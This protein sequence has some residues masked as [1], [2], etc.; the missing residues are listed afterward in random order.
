MSHKVSF[1]GL[2]ERLL[3]G[4][5]EV[6]PQLG[7]QISECEGVE[8]CA[9]KGDS[10]SIRKAE[11]AV[12]ITYLREHQFFRML[13]FLPGVLKG[14]SGREEKPSFGMLCYMADMSRNAV[15]NLPTAKR[16]LRYLALMGYDSLMLYTED[17]FELPGY[18]YFGHMRGRFSQEELKEIDDYAYDLGIEVIP[19]VQTLAHLA[20]ALR[21]PGF[22]FQDTGDI[23]LVGDERTY[24]F[25][26]AILGVCAKCFRSRRINVGM[27][28]A[29]MLARGAYLDKNGYRP[30]SEVMLEHLDR[31]VK[32]CAENGFTPMIWSDM[33]FRM[34]FGGRYRVSEGEIAQEII[35]KVPESL[36]LIYWDYYSLDRGLFSH[37]LDCHKKF[38]NPVVFA[39]GAWKWYGFAPHNRFSIESTRMQLDVCR[40]KGVDNIIV[41]SWGDNGGEA[42]Q[43]SVL[44]A[45]IYFAE[46]G[47]AGGDV[48][49]ERLEERCLECFGIGY[50][51]LLTLD[52][53]NELPGV[54]VE[55]GRPVNPSRYLLFN[56][57]LEGLLDVHMDPE[58]TPAGFA[59]AA[60]RLFKYK[61]DPNF[62]YIFNTLGKLS[63][64]LAVKCDISVR[65]R[66]AYKR[67][68][69]DI[70]AELARVTI[71]EIIEK[72]DDFIKTFREQWYAENKTFGFSVQE[73]RL[74]GLRARLES[75]ALR[76]EAFAAGKIKRIEELEQPVLSF[77]G[78]TYENG[79]LP[80]ISH[81]L[82]RQY[83]TGGVL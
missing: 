53:P 48:P 9:V 75:T 64:L 22:G 78:K 30:P 36:T 47:F 41:T 23:L 21:W 28:E 69:R 34:A 65:A 71:P 67:E 6:A 43:F 79:S 18:L 35:D 81:M 1:K 24:K 55:I 74:G 68:D 2:D 63:Q 15:Y 4:A 14:G 59:N 77:N 29:H 7:L 70:L 17:T 49:Q 61:D 44:P 10:P 76:L 66:E 50:E 39:G 8:V 73:I 11:N 33:F 26:D 83:V 5:A 58:D 62:G 3:R 54:T 82:W 25:I 46:R 16:M 51:A 13:S 60:K 72:L 31:V 20:T 80:Y 27:D 52:A 56:D 19:C 45:M 42:S 40:E 38:K 32:L 37:M 12:I 57:P